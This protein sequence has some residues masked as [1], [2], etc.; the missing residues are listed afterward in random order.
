MK[1]QWQVNGLGGTL[2]VIIKLGASPAFTPSRNRRPQALDRT[3]PVQV[4]EVFCHGAMDLKEEPALGAFAVK[5]FGKASELD[6]VCTQTVNR[7]HHFHKRT[8]EAIEFPYDQDIV[9]TKIGEGGFQFRTF[10]ASLA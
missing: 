1:V 9:R 6:P 10:A 5:L 2:V 8:P 7:P 4:Q 3:F